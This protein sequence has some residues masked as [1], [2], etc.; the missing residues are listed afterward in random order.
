MI[1]LSKVIV[2]SRRKIH[3]YFDVTTTI[4]EQQNTSI[5]SGICLESD[6]VTYRL[7]SCCM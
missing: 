7:S 1:I 5:N 2:P 6:F 4:A 3:I